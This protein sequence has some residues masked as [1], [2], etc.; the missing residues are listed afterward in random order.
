[1]HGERNTFRGS[2]SRPSSP[3]WGG[4]QQPVRFREKTS[5]DPSGPPPCLQTQGPLH[6]TLSGTP[7]LSSYCGGVRGAGLRKQ[8]LAVGLPALGCRPRAECPPC[9]GT[10]M[11]SS[12][13]CASPAPQWWCEALM[14]VQGRGLQAEACPHG[15]GPAA[16]APRWFTGP[17]RTGRRLGGGACSGGDWEGDRLCH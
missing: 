10:M 16:R 15:V 2:G 3:A 4:E 13:V 12:R 11:V 14:A 6:V 9:C 7:H 5:A 17:V 8:C 1:M